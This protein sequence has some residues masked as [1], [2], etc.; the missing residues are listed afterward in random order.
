MSVKIISEIRSKVYYKNKIVFLESVYYLYQ[1]LVPTRNGFT[2][3]KIGSFRSDR[4]GWLNS[5]SKEVEWI[6]S[7]EIQV[8]IGSNVSNLI[9][10]NT[11]WLDTHAWNWCVSC[12]MAD[13]EAPSKSDSPCKHVLGLTLL[14]FF[15]SDSTV[16]PLHENMT[17]LVQ[18][19]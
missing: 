1:R 15:R 19:R 9:H 4:I 8:R 3:K 16:N 2:Q 5:I 18:W 13:I 14:A 12:N 10:V 7:A 11:V 17:L 6:D